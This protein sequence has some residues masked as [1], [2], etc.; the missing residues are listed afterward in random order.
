VD[1]SALNSS[2]F[3]KRSKE[4]ALHLVRSYVLVSAHNSKQKIENL[5]LSKFLMAKDRR[6]RSQGSI[7]VMCMSSRLIIQEKNDREILHLLYSLFIAS[8]TDN[9]VLKS[10][11]EMLMY[12]NVIK[13]QTQNEPYM[14]SYTV[15]KLGGNVVSVTYMLKRR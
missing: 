4:A 15:L 11:H 13:V 7:C 3:V 10:S 8:V 14:V 12:S 1:C 6:S 5:S 2:Q 9:A